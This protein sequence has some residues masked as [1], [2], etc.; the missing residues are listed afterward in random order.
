M[1]ARVKNT[2]YCQMKDRAARYCVDISTVQ[3]VLHGTIQRGFSSGILTMAGPA[4]WQY[5]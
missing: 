1:M 3:D 5:Q 4:R 2:I